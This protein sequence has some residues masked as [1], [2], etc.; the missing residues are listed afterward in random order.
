MLV[1]FLIPNGRDYNFFP[2]QI[3]DLARN[4]Y[5]NATVEKIALIRFMTNTERKLAGHVDE[6][7]LGVTVRPYSNHI[8]SNL[9]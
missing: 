1:V 8:P 3:G 7:T 6:L 4:I 2:L 5:Y 9:I